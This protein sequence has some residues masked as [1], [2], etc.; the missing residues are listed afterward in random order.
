MDEYSF[1]RRILGDQAR[2]DLG[3]MLLALARVRGIDAARE[4]VRAQH[5]ALTL[6]FASRP[7]D[8]EKIA[9]ACALAELDTLSAW[10]GTDAA[11]PGPPPARDPGAY[12]RLGALETLRA[13]PI[14][15]FTWH[16]AVAN[17]AAW[18]EAIADT[19]TV[20]INTFPWITHDLDA[21]ALMYSRGAGRAAELRA[22][23]AAL[24]IVAAD[25][26]AAIAN[27]I[28]DTLAR[29]GGPEGISRDVA[30]HNLASSG[31]PQ[32]L[33]ALAL[34]V[35]Q[36]EG[37][38][39][40]LAAS[41]SRAA[42][43]VRLARDKASTELT[44]QRSERITRSIEKAAGWVHHINTGDL[45]AFEDF[46]RLVVTHPDAFGAGLSAALRDVVLAAVQDCEPTPAPI[47]KP[48]LRKRA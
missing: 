39:E 33:T 45:S 25:V 31:E 32:S 48:T 16:Q 36:L 38:F 35:R 37:E 29:F 47:P 6:R 34:Q 44:Q 19:L 9:L 7:I 26:G 46:M 27:H 40:A 17:H 18:C 2:V 1:H 43:T 28:P 15:P 41:E 20:R 22:V 4:A 3:P 5:H 30:G 42:E 12:A 13:E 23:A 11:E 8:A 14:H 21:C 10:L 24:R